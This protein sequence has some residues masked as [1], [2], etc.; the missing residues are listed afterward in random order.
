METSGKIH[1][2]SLCRQIENFVETRRQQTLQMPTTTT[3]SFFGSHSVSK[4]D[5]SSLN[6][7][8]RVH[9]NTSGLLTVLGLARADEGCC[10]VSKL[11]QD[12]EKEEVVGV[13]AR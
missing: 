6:Q 12:C 7:R 8:A 1:V 5:D 10:F 9:S 11:D 13:V 3:N 4:L 2:G